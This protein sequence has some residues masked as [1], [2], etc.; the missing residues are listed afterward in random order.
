MKQPDNKRLRER[1][2]HLYHQDL[3]NLTALGKD[4]LASLIEELN[5]HQI[6]LELQNEELQD[7]YRQ[8]ELTSR[9]FSDIFEHAPMGFLVIDEEANIL[10]A[11]QR[12]L[13]MTGK[14]ARQLLQQPFFT[15]LKSDTHRAFFEARTACLHDQ[16]RVTFEGHL[17]TKHGRS[18]FV[19]L[20]C[21]PWR[22]EIQE[23]NPKQ[24]ILISLH[25]ISSLK[26]AHEKLDFQAQVLDQI[27]DAITVTDLE[28]RITYINQAVSTL[29]GTPPETLLGKMLSVYGED[30]DRGASQEEILE[31]T[32]QNGTWRGEVVNHTR[33]G[34]KIILDCRTQVVYDHQHH[35]TALV[36]ISTDISEQ[37]RTV[38]EKNRLLEAISQTLDT[39]VIFDPSGN[40]LFVNEAFQRTTGLDPSRVLGKSIFDS[41]TGFH[42]SASFEEIWTQLQN[43]NNWQGRLINCRASGDYFTEEVTISPVFSNHG[44]IES[45]VA[46][47]RDITR[48][49]IIEKENAKLTAELRQT[50]KMES[51][52]HLAGGMAHDLNNLLTPVLG[53]AELLLDDDNLRED[54]KDAIQEIIGAGNRSRDLIHHL[55]AFSRR[56]TLKVRSLYLSE[57]LNQFM[58]LLRRTLREDIQITVATGEQ[59][60]PVLADKGQLEQVILNLVVNAQDA[61]PGGGMLHLSIGFSEVDDTVTLAHPGLRQ[62]EYVSLVVRDSGCGFDQTIAEHLFDPFFTTKDKGKGTGLGLSTVYGIIKQHQGYIWAESQ[63]GHGASFTILLPPTAQQAAE[64]ITPATPPSLQGKETILLAE[65]SDQ[66]RQLVQLILERHGYTVVAAPDGSTL[67]QLLDKGTLRGDLLITDIVM[68]DMTGRQLQETLHRRQPNLKVLFMSGYSAEVISQKGVLLKDTH[69][70]QKPFSMV[71]LTRKV[72]LLLDGQKPD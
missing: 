62:G 36:G 35:P 49:L 45:F 39:I 66:V 56:Q 64:V 52:G 19:H 24:Q 58:P 42:H 10:Q 41:K 37:T 28:G 12:L 5:I 43:G 22:S 1:A 53:Y 50:L 14:E 11:N 27:N 70:L 44:S 54:Q 17:I 18:L 63:P 59:E 38:S 7:T 51:I 16:N 67:L 15:L 21:S 72:R 20:E 2:Q 23:A 25:D 6:E 47:K 13:D 8:L 34:R 3:D 33:D 48:E 55:L 61:M 65:D 71:D 60:K 31:S 68:P 4:D 26:T 57:L 69:F 46:V 40:I 30:T 9:R 29:L 32:R